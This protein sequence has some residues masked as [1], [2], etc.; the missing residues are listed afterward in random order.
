MREV[1]YVSQ[2][3]SL[4]WH[5]QTSPSFVFAELSY[6][7]PASLLAGKEYF[8]ILEIL[9]IKYEKCQPILGILKFLELRF[10]EIETPGRANVT[11]S[12]QDQS[13]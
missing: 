5:Q 4:E 13:N 3:R 11:R 2:V 10:Q 7:I 12:R 8:W 1:L 6:R 9:E